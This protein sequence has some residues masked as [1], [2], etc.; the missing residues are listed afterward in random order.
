VNQGVP[1]I[2]G[3]F[4][5]VSKSNDDARAEWAEYYVNYAMSKDI[6]CFWWD[7]GVSSGDGEIF[8]LFNRRT[9]TV[10]SPQIVNALMTGLAGWTAP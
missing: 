5:A 3:E 4:G 6:P 7:N 9:N 2:I 8:A 1:V 10:S